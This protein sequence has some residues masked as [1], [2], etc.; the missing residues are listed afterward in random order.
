M[1]MDALQ[2]WLGIIDRQLVIQRSGLSAPTLSRLANGH[3]CQYRTILAAYAAVVAIVKE[4][5]AE[6]EG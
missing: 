6:L 3:S 1:N 2:K 4:A 5:Q